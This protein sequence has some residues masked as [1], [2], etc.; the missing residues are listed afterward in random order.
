MEANPVVPA[1]VPRCSEIRR[2]A[3][4]AAKR[5]ARSARAGARVSSGNRLDC[6]RV[7]RVVGSDFER[8]DDVLIMDER[9]R[10]DPLEI[11]P[12]HAAS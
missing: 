6:V 10:P 1:R 9:N 3:R 2:S 4:I 12:A 11:V 7:R 8:F 5:G